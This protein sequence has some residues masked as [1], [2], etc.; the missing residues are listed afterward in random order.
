VV[1]HLDLEVRKEERAYLDRVARRLTKQSPVGV[2][3]ALLEGDDVAESLYARAAGGADL[4]VLSTH[5][6]GPLQRFWLGSVADDLVR[7]VPVPVLLVRPK[8]APPD[9]TAEPALKH[10]LI[11]LDGTP[12]AEQVVGPALDVGGLMGASFTLLRVIKP[13][14]RVNYLPEGSTLTGMMSAMLERV[15]ADQKQMEQEARSYLEGVA[16]KARARGVP[17]Q[18]R[19]A[20]DEQPAVGILRQAEEVFAG[21]LALATHGRRGLSRIVLGSVADKVV[22]GTTLPVL[23]YRPRQP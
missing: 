16:E 14:L 1:D 3:P 5:G 13:A 22:R 11:P 23:L 8:P 9:F 15:Q 4:V 17:V 19:V 2:T 18:L 12:L 20:V 6:R 7:R 10:F 21:A